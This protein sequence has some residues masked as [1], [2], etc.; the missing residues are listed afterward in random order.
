MVDPMVTTFLKRTMLSFPTKPIAPSDLF[1]S[2]EDAG[3]NFRV[4][5]FWSLLWFTES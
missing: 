3:V 2:P 5:Q 1:T 4:Q